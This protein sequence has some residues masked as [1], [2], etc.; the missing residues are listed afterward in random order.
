MQIIPSSEIKNLGIIF[1][2][3]MKMSSHITAL[4]RSLNF[5]LWN[6]FRIR[7]YVDQ[8][9]CIN[10]MRAL[11]LS[12]LDYGNAFLSGCKVTDI[13]RLQHIQNRTA[14]I[15]FQVLRCHPSSELLDSLHW[16]PTEKCI[17]FKI[18]LHIY[19]SL[20]DLSPKYLADCFKI[21]IPPREGLRSRRNS[22]CRP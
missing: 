18:L 10:A 5:S 15:V 21:Y 13:A 22:S 6:I 7:H 16:L 3:K 20:N 12:K 19:K 1:D 17:I 4:Y 14:R 11:I 8:E 2:S 9:T